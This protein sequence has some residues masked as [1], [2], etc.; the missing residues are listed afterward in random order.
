MLKMDP[1]NR[2]SSD[3]TKMEL[4][5]AIFVPHGRM[6]PSAGTGFTWWIA[7][8]IDGAVPGTYCEV[9]IARSEMELPR[10]AD[11]T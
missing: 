1:E 10:Y 2:S 4:C 3:E 7:G 11:K 5:A 9:G 6:G 8:I